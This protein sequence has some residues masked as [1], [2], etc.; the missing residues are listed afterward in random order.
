[1]DNRPIGIFDSSSGG[2]SIWQSFQTL[3]PYESSVYVGDHAFAP[4]STKTT[5]YIRKRACAMIRFLLSKDVKLIIV[6]CNTAT[7]AGIDY[8]RTVFPTIPIIGVVPVIKTAAEKTKNQRIGVFSTLYTKKSA[9]QKKLLQTFASDKHI[10]EVG[11]ARLVSLIETKPMHDPTLIAYVK[12][13]VRPFKT[14]GIDVLVLG[15]THFPFVRSHIADTLGD[16]VLLLDS[17]EPV[18]RHTKDVLEKEHLLCDVH[19]VPVYQFFTSGNP[20]DVQETWKR[21][22]GKEIEVHSLDRVQ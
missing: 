2:L 3:L 5:D 4:Y 18:I 17:G 15:C 19:H 11:S 16:H 6:A 13:I 10:K 21:L 14:Y 1:M 22:L 20:A 7:V 8:Y 12:K 9:Y